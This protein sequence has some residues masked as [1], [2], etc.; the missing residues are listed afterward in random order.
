MPARL[1]AV[2]FAVA[3][4]LL[5]PGS[6]QGQLS[7]R[8]ELKEGAK[9]SDKTIVL[10]R[11]E[12]EDDT[13]IQKVEFLLDGELK[14]TDTS[15][16]YSFEW[17]T[18]EG[19]EGSHTLTATAFDARG[20]TARAK[21]TVTV[22]NELGKGAEFHAE[23]SL[24]ALRARDMETAARF[25]RRALKIDPANLT[26]A[27]A[28]AGL[29]RQR[30][31][32]AEAI[33]VLEKANIPD[34]HVEA[35]ADLAASHIAHGA[36]GDSTEAFL[37][38]AAAANEAYQKVVTARLAAVRGAQEAW[39]R[40]D[41]QFAARN[42]AAAIREYQ[43][44]GPAEEAPIEC[45]NR[46]LLAYLKAGRLRDA[47]TVM[48]MLTRS[49]RADDATQAIH[50]LMLLNDHQ[51]L[52]AR[53]VVQDGVAKRR[54]PAL[55]IAA[56]A[57]L[58]LERRPQAMEEARQ[59]AAIAP[60]LPEVQLLMAHVLPDPIDARRALMRALEMDP[61]LAEAYALHGFHILL[62]RDRRRFQAADPVFEFALKR[63][64]N[65]NY[66]L[67]GA[68]LSLMAQRRPNE[69][70]PLL[71]QLLQQDRNAADAYVAQ[72]LNYSLLDRS[73]LITPALDM[74]RKLDEDR[75]NYA[76]VPDPVEL[77]ARVYRFRRAPVL[78]PAA[79][80]AE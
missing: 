36:A 55:L 79:L 64:P 11:V 34:D 1:Y 59:A 49:K 46:L 65:N 78:T 25:A 42:W 27:R 4:W 44:C 8:F 20:R 73:L 71:T 39:K 14:A 72:A 41:A 15:V 69:A 80:Y 29:Y 5:L 12:S 35:W 76:L 16:P 30:R 56:Y 13:G 33:A 9:V 52:K 3:L 66:A 61:A 74:A 26:A 7:V 77:I 38:G 10:V 17:D 19:E 67:M 2:C 54:L 37:R 32:Y 63:D 53:E 21:I 22:D 60:N 18:L 75:W 28:L 57:D 62:S 45:V 47:Q 6:A 43:Q 70:E 48:G 23:A 51:L 24:A 50:G 31:Q 40:G 58:S 68:A